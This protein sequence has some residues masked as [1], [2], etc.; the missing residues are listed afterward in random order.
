M[1]DKKKVYIETYGCSSNQMDSQ[2][3]GGTLKQKGYELVENDEKADLVILNLCS[4]KQKTENKERHRIEQLRNKGKKLVLAG[5]LPEAVNLGKDYPELS[6]IGTNR[7]AEIETVVD[8]TLAGEKTVLLGKSKTPKVLMPKIQNGTIRIMEVQSGCGYFCSFCSTKFAK[9]GQYP[10]PAR[11]IVKEIEL[12]LVEGVREFWITGQEVAG[13]NDN[14]ILLPDLINKVTALQGDFFIRIGM[15]HPA[16]VLPIIDELIEAY[17][18]GK[19]FKFLHVPQQ[20]GSNSMLKKM[21]RKNSTDEYKIVIKKFKAAFPE[22]T[23][24][25]DI[26]VGHPAETEEEFAETVRF[27]EETRP[28]FVNISAYGWRPNT[29]A[30][31]MKQVA[32]D[33]KKE[34][35][36]ILTRLVKDLM[37]ESNQRWIGW[38]GTVLVDEYKPDKGTWLGRNYAYKPVVLRG[39]HLAGEVVEV[40]IA[41]AEDTHL[42]Q[43]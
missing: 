26:I 7:V 35:T 39:P 12:S 20:S 11:D 4:V 15:L 18:S 19:V 14:G 24:W 32:S 23:V 40:E 29:P 21:N 9:G 25:T 10:Y 3:M 1:S 43:S 31:K 8:N 22:M 13:Y 6:Q 27:I 2:I 38:K 28:D 41:R 37:L 16:S 30:A 33:I 42:E 5:C 17:K 34:R 36:R